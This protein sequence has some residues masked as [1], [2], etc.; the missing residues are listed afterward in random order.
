MAGKREKKAYRVKKKRK[1][2]GLWTKLVI[3]LIV[4]YFVFAFYQ[5]SLE[6]RELAAEIESLSQEKVEI[7]QR[8]LEM[9][10]LLEKGD[11]DQ[12]IERLAREN[13]LMK[14]PGEQV[15]VFESNNSLGKELRERREQDREDED[16]QEDSSD[17]ETP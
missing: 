3:L 7:E 13:L 2:M 6:R 16:S 14:K 15:Y 9:E 12:A 11:S 10:E 1:K 8:I 5:Q 4:G 17:E